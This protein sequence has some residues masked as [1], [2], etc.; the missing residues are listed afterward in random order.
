VNSKDIDIGGGSFAGGGA[1]G[2]WFAFYFDVK[3]YTEAEAQG[4]LEVI[5]HTPA[6]A[7]AG[8]R[9]R[10][11]VKVRNNTEISYT[12]ANMVAINFWD[13]VVAHTANFEIGPYEEKNITFSWYAPQDAG[14]ITVAAMVNPDRAHPESDYENNRKEFGFTVA[15]QVELPPEEPPDAVPDEEIAEDGYPNN[16]GGH[17]ILI[18]GMGIDLEVIDIIPGRYPAG[19]K[20]VTLVEVRNN[21]GESL[22]GSRA[23][24]VKMSVPAAGFSKSTT[25][26]LDANAEQFVAFAWTAP[27]SNQYFTITAEVNPARAIPETSYSNNR[28]TVNASSDVPHNPPYGCNITRRTWTESRFSHTKTVR[29]VIDGEVHEDE[30]DVYVDVEFYAEVSI[31]ARLLPDEMKSGYG[32]E[33]E[34]VTYISTD[35]DKPEEITG[36]QS[37][38]AYSPLDGY[39]E[40]V[41]LELVH[42]AGNKWRFPV[43]PT[44]VKGLRVMYVPVEWPDDSFFTVGFTGRDAQCPGG[45]M[46]ATTEASVYIDGNMYQDDY[47]SP[48]RY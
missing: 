6:R 24:E 37:V 9:V 25:V 18:N 32:V 35:Y 38:Y 20:V 39:Y 41:E 31:S 1:A 45:A 7:E 36:L 14:K 40:A 22:R 19:K 16:K 26:A 44:S 17:D 5:G 47:T 42:G 29:T 43:N 13:G 11:Q 46:C 3:F 28:L 2:L 48:S 30:E 8:K 12:E 34:V 23:V 33:C 15:P 4:D 27:A 21:S 10:S